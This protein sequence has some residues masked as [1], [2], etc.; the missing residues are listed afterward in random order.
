[1]QLELPCSAYE[2]SLEF[3]HEAAMLAS[4]L[5]WPDGIGAPRCTR[6]DS[7]HRRGWCGC[8]GLP[9][10]PCPGE[11]ASSAPLHAPPS[12]PALSL[13]LSFAR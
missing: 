6:P 13:A 1:M 10:L 8:G 7:S 2:Y 12:V 4:P 3:D 5:Y 11:D 9:L